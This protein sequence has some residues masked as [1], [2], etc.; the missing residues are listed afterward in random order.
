[1][2]TTLRRLALTAIC[3]VA[4]HAAAGSSQAGYGYGPGY[5]Y[6]PCHYKTVVTYQYLQEPYYEYVTLYD[7]CGHPYA[8]KQLAYRTITVPVTTLVKV[9][10]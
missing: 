3:G 10:Y 9:C 6:Q 2:M 8:A 4:L 7:H 1:M 5:G